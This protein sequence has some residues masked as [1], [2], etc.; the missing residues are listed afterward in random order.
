[1]KIPILLSTTAVFAVVC[2]LSATAAVAETVAEWKFNMAADLPGSSE[3]APDFVAEGAP[4]GSRLQEA[5]GYTAVPTGITDRWPDFLTKGY[6]EV[7]S[8]SGEQSANRH[9]LLTEG[10]Y[11][12]YFGGNFLDSGAAGLTV[13]LVVQPGSDWTSGT[14]R[15]LFSVGD[16][17]GKAASTGSIRLMARDGRLQFTVGKGE[18]GAGYDLTNDGDMEDF[19]AAQSTVTQSWD[20]S[21]WYLIAASAQEGAAPVL[22]V[23]EMAPEGPAGSPAAE[24]GVPTPADET[25]WESV[26]MEIRL[27]KEEPMALGATWVS[28]GNNPH[29]Q[30]GADAKIAYARIDNTFSTPEE[31]ERVFADLSRRDASGT[32]TPRA[33]ANQPRTP[34]DV[35]T[36]L[37][38]DVS[39]KGRELDLTQFRKT[40][41]DDFKT[42]SV[43]HDE[44][45]SGPWYAP[46][47]TDFGVGRFMAPGA[48][49]TYA[50]VAD[51]L[52]IRANQDEKGKWRTGNIQTVDRK[53]RGF[54]QKYGYFEMTVQF[55]KGNGSWIGLWLLS[56]NGYSDPSQ[57]RTEIDIIEWY[58]GDPSGHHPT[59]HLWPA[60]A[61]YRP[62]DATITKHLGVS[63]FKQGVGRRFFQEMLVD[64]RLPGFH[65]YGAE[66][67]PKWVIIYFDR[68]E[69]GR[70]PTVEEFKTPLYMVI[71]L[72]LIE[73][74]IA[75]AVPPIDL[76]VKNVS[77][78]EPATP[79][80]E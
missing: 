19:V 48:D 20:P 22:F 39:Q 6:I 41:N 45:G 47:H 51:G 80:S 3:V 65:A 1:M 12:K 54:A 64:G 18:A 50:L 67:T 72:A 52:R 73:K 10:D 38:W 56:R 55:P 15:G 13:Y 32:A 60:N 77:A 36:A 34:A 69:I 28:F 76:I 26:P 9:G 33:A 14:R 5:T 70:I 59:V 17:V 23:R 42:M 58:G 57:T 61:R 31:M 30:D 78:Y 27:K 21:K 75:K 79:Y 11:R 25:L 16:W 62:A 2:A 35:F 43:T 40:F 44:T 46:G 66:V 4:A 8:G 71:S 37:Q 7:G 49:D 29:T 53:G 74:D 63:G 24:I 68:K